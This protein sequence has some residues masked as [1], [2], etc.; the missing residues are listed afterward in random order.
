MCSGE[1]GILPESLDAGPPLHLRVRAQPLQR[2][3]RE[4]AARRRHRDQDR[5]VGQAGHGRPPAGRQGDRGDRGGPRLPGRGRHPQPGPLRRHPERRG[6]ARPRWRGCARQSGGRPIGI[7]L[8]AGNIEADLEVALPAE[9]DFITIDGRPGGTGASP[10]LVKDATSVPTIFALHRARR[11]LDA[12]GATDVSLVITGGLR[13]SS[14]FAKALALGADA[15]A[16][17]TAALMAWAAS[18][19]ASATPGS[20]RWG[21]RPRTR[22]CGRDS[23]S[24]RPPPGWRTSCGCARGS[25]TTSPG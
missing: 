12:R 10:K 21:S 17:G 1:G 20:A 9:P 15:V 11:F 22:S 4:P 19:T 24:T 8:A 14:D 25:S 16:I 18:S 6:P 13:V 2:H 23:T 5:P 3:R 7:K